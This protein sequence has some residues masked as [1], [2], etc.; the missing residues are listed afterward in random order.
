[1]PLQFYLFL[2][3]K[4]D[5]SFSNVYCYEKG[6]LFVKL[7]AGLKV[8]SIIQKIYYRYLSFMF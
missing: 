4:G 2:N 5:K 3:F 6:C 8:L 7:V 1:M